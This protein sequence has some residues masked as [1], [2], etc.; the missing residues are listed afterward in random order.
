MGNSTI[1]WTEKTWNPVT[2]CTK[3]SLGCTHCYAA[4][5]ARRLQAMGKPAYKNGFE[6][7][8]HPELLDLPDHWRKPSRVFANSM[9][10]LF[11]ED[12]PEAFIKEV[13]EVMERNPRHTFQVLTKRS[14]R[15]A[16]LAHKLPWPANVWMG[17]SVETD[18][19]YGRISDLAKVPAHIRFLSCEPLL[20]PLANLPLDGIHWVIAGGESDPGARPMDADWVRDIRDQCIARNIPFFFKQWGGRNKKKAGKE[21]DGREWQ[22]MPSSSATK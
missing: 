3:V 22:Q 7:A 15:L 17:V 9:S 8:T 2:G 16:Q 14:E 6:P 11:H 18:R 19:Y 21:L 4:L 1:E 13:F 10:D 5:M 12:V 20:G